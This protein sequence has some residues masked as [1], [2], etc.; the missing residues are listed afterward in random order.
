M[1]DHEDVF[2]RVVCVLLFQFVYYSVERMEPS[3]GP[4]C[5]TRIDVSSEEH[6][7]LVSGAYGN[8]K[9]SYPPEVTMGQC[10]CVANP[11]RR[12]FPTYAFYENPG[13]HFSVGKPG[14]RVIASA[15]CGKPRTPPD[16]P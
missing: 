14:S 13:K 16:S 1:F 7:W 3:D 5:R 11:D 8:S 12:G 6:E 10:N 4:H 9:L 15:F 2:R